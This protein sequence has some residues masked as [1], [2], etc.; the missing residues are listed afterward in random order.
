M[1]VGLV[2]RRAGLG[3]DDGGDGLAELL[4][5]HADH[6]GVA[7]R[8]VLLEHLLDLLGEDLLA[9]GVDAHRAAAEQGDRAVGLDRRVVAGDRVALAVD[10]ENVAADFS[11]SL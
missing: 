10:L 4:V 11:G 5:G 7:H 3:L 6:H 9:A 2:D 8:G 1:S